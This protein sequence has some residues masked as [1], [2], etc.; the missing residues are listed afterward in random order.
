VATSPAPQV[1]PAALDIAGVSVLTKTPS[2][3]YDPSTLAA[4]APVW[5][6]PLIDGRYLMASQRRWYAATADGTTPGAYT[7][8][9]EDTTPSWVIFDTR[10]TRV[11]VPSTTGHTQPVIPMN[12]AVDSATLIGGASR[13]PEFLY[14]LHAVSIA[15]VLGG[16]LQHF[17]AMPNGAITL[18]GEELL[19]VV[20]SVVFDR[21]V[22][23]QTPYLLVYGS[24]ASGNVY[25]IRK[26]WARIGSNVQLLSSP[27]IHPGVVGTQA[28]WEYH[29]GNGYSS[30]PSEL[31]PVGGLTT[32]R[33]MSFAA[34]Q[35]QVLATTVSVASGVYT[36]QCWV[37]N[38]GATFAKLGPA[39]A[40][41]NDADGSYL[42]GG[43]H[44]MPLL[45]ANPTLVTG[46][47]AFPYVVWTKSTAGSSST[48]LN[49]WAL[50][51]V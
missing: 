32:V 19:P 40:L 15:G 9:T 44:L 49:T 37:S 29:T 28:G 47:A 5:V 39:V 33:A 23:Y 27:Q 20:G 42:G 16:L 24:D 26:P 17:T 6:H 10:G 46:R 48:L 2:A 21:G 45:N 3:L 7:A 8:Y 30:D 38:A 4:A 51:Q 41:G 18:S 50:L 11:Q 14:L 1:S 35:K 25:R 36:G 31:A 34:Y 13:P 22:Q 43:I 12:T